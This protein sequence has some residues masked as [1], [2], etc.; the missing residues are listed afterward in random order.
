MNIKPGAV[1]P[2][3]LNTLSPIISSIMVNCSGDQFMMHLFWLI[4]YR[5]LF[6]L[7]ITLGMNGR[8][9]KEMEAFTRHLVWISD[10][11]ENLEGNVR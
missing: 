2:T 4:R 1:C 11:S 7:G 8:D 6:A 5:F 3:M 10:R 9:V